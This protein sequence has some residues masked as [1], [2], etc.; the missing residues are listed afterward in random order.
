M[1]DQSEVI[2][3]IVGEA[4][5]TDHELQKAAYSAENFHH[6]EIATPDFCPGVSCVNLNEPVKVFVENLAM[7]DVVH[8]YIFWAKGTGNTFAVL[9]RIG[10]IFA[11]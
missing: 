4:D 8:Y 7:E 5:A 2:I 3:E 9:A 1:P 10:K 11:E 6:V